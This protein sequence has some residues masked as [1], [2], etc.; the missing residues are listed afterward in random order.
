M[1][2]IEFTP[3]ND[4]AAAACITGLSAQGSINPRVLLHD[5]YRIVI[6]M[7]PSGDDG[8]FEWHVSVSKDSL[9]VPIAKVSE[10]G[11]VLIPSFDGWH[12]VSV[13]HT[14]THAWAKV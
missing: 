2:S 10:Y 4:E 7:D 13:R 5:G 8:A 12:W 3:A 11:R 6:S 1:S 9:R 14:A